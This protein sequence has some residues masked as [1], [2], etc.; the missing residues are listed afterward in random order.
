MMADAWTVGRIAP[1]STHLK[2]GSFSAIHVL[3]RYEVL[4]AAIRNSDEAASG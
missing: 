4:P 3:P 2:T 1:V